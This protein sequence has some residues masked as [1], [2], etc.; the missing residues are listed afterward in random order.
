MEQVKLDQAIQL[1]FEDFQKATGFQREERSEFAMAMPKDWVQ[2]EDC[3]E[4][5]DFLSVESDANEFAA[6]FQEML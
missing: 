5:E 2:S 3:S 6:M 4:S 1:R